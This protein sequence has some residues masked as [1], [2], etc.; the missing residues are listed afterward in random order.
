MGSSRG[1]LIT[2][3]HP[4]ANAN[5]LP[6]AL[7]LTA[8]QAHDGRNAADMLD[9][10]NEGDM[11]LAYRAYDSDALRSEMAARAC[12]P[13]SSPCQPANAVQRSVP[14]SI[15]TATSSS[16]YLPKSS[17]SMPSPRAMTSV[18]ITSSLQSNSPPN[19]IWLRHNESVA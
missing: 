14:S 2:K 17:S 1:G 7:K 19:R 16:T 4:L 3:I 18:T 11:L 12:G 8:A 13:T 9:T 6:I 5:S 15:G 10:L